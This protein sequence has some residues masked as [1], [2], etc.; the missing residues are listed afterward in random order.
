MSSKRKPPI[1]P[2][3]VANKRILADRQARIDAQKTEEALATDLGLD[4]KPEPSQ[5]DDPVEFLRDEF[6]R[7]TFGEAFPT[8]TR[9]VYGPDPL[10]TNCPEIKDRIE[11]MGLERYAQI[12]AETILQKGEK[13]VPNPFMQKGLRNAIAKFGA[14]KVADAFAKRILQ[15]P[16]HTV[17]VEADR[18]DAMIFAQPMEEAVQM[19][20]TPGMRA[21]FL[22]ERCIGVLG[23]RGYQIVKDKKGDPV[24][25]G[26]LIMG[27]IPI[28]MAEARQR[29]FAQESENAVAEAEEAFENAS[30]RAMRDAGGAP[31]VSVLRDRDNVTASASENESLVGR[32]RETGFKVERQ[33]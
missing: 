1:D 5:S 33:R 31:G 25:V 29:H 16:V 12:T 22:S 18:S 23:M 13:A 24:K 10:L 32:S 21:K 9:I 4:I 11:A 3:E 14:Q 7:K 8:F 2:A 30:E 6:D 26:T 15:I 17:E 28:R 20:G 19:Y 27:E